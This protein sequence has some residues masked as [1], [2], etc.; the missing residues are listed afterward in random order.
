M[1][2]FIIESGGNP[3]KRGEKMSFNDDVYK[4]VRSIP[5]GYVMSYGQ[6]ARLAGSPRASRAAGYAMFWCPYDDIPCHRVLYRDGSLS[7]SWAFGGKQR[8]L[9]ME[10][11]V[12]FLA[13]GRVDMKEHRFTGPFPMLFEQEEEEDEE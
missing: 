13:D 3:A 4:I 12:T 6:L 2:A 1:F 8:E 5:E 10:E 9:L 11:G 7:P